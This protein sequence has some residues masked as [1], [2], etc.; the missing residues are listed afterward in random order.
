VDR[1]FLPGP[2]E[3]G[4]WLIFVSGLALLVAVVLIPAG[5]DLADARAARDEALA[6]ERYELER[7]DRYE[8]YLEALDRRDDRLLR[9]LAMSQLRLTPADRHV[10]LP[11]GATGDIDLFGPIEPVPELD[12][13]AARPVSTLEDLATHQRK[14]LWLIAGGVLCLFVGLLPPGR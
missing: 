5:N 6:L 1:S 10:L 12:E 2:G 3:L 13:P 7:L 4:S 8:T 14:R 11:V 9:S